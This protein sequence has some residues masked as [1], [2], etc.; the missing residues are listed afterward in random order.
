MTNEW[1]P[2]QPVPAKLPLST[3]PDGWPGQRP[4]PPLHPAERRQRNL[5]IA[6]SIGGVLV[7][8]A[9][10]IAFVA[11]RGGGES[12]GPATVPSSAP[13]TSLADEPA[14]T[15]SEP[16]PTTVET[17]TTMPPTTVAILA[18]ADAGADLA[19]DQSVEF[20]LV[21]AGLAAGTPSAA[22]RWTQIAGPDVTAGV[23][24]LRGAEAVAIAPSEVTTLAFTL[25]VAGTDGVATDDVI[26][27][28]FEAVSEA[29]FIDGELGD[30]GA[31]GSM[32]APLRSLAAAVQSAP[33]RDLYTRS[34]GVYDT[35]SATLELGD[36]VSL[37]GGFDESWSRDTNRRTVIDGSAIAIRATGSTSRTISAV[38]VMAGDADPG[39]NSA[40]IVVEGA[41]N[42]GL[43][44]SRVIGGEGGSGVDGGTGGRSSGVVVNGATEMRIERSTVNAGRGGAGGAGVR[45][46][47]ATVAAASGGDGNGIDR[48]AGG[49]TGSSMGG[50]GGD[51]GNASA[52]QDAPG[53]ATGGT[54]ESPD[55]RA[56]RGGSGGAGG[57]GGDGAVGA[58]SA[59][60]GATVPAGRTGTAGSGG[61]AG[62]GGPGG[63]G[64]NGPVAGAVAG[65]GGAGGGA[66]GAP[67]AGAAPGGGG[68]G[69]I[70][71][72]TVDVD[73]LVIIE[74]LVAGGR[75]GN[76]G[77]GAA[78]TAG[79]VG[80]A[81]GRGAQGM[82]GVPA[83][84]GDGGGAGGG[85]A[86]GTGGQG[87]GGAGGPSYGLLTTNVS[88]IEVSA[89][90]VR[91]GGG[92]NGA[93][94][95]AGGPAGLGGADGS[96]R[97]GGAGGS[98][99]VDGDAEAGNGASG[100]ASYGWFDDNA[101]E[102]LLDPAQFNEGSA[103]NGGVGSE[104]GDDG[105]GMAIN[106]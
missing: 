95:G 82:D 92:G 96:G 68:G 79:Q 63:G 77:D 85:G 28:V 7:L 46:D 52:G 59:D 104:P 34:V 24:S 5:I 54:P 65:G 44:D 105:V 26:V 17:T 6:L 67:T 58:I 83:D 97:T 21:A 56:G 98:P 101:A 55:G 9:G 47:Q 12:A 45:V 25:E 80:G 48:G 20:R 16:A 72:W 32:D 90:T 50:R 4:R 39:G 11:T 99:S 94:G 2:E 81:G 76:G 8:I 64:G 60:D 43:L 41:G 37:Y 93:D 89:T 100:G 69:S 78:A 3:R 27:R 36:G 51:G 73:R 30:D 31:A 66:G 38:E 33:G 19:V 70:G 103:G 13:G 42:V 75:A 15:S 106:L 1:N 102:Q 88:S 86:G 29:V 10:M 14:P 62:S 18:N 22:V 23:G 61:A 35:T 40:G 53:G 87:G 91:G 57:N 71:V 84:G 74:S 49:G